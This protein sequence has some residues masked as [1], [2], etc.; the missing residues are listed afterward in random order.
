MKRLLPLAGT[1][2]GALIVIALAFED[3]FWHPNQYF[4]AQG[5]DGFKN[6]FTPAWYLKYDQ[7]WQ[8]SGMNYPYGEHVVFTDNQPLISG[9]LNFIDNNL[10]ELHAYTVG[11]L[12]LLLFLSIALA[13]GCLYLICRHYGIPKW[14]A[15]M[16]AI[17]IVFLSPQLHRFHGHYA[18]GYVVYLPLLWWVQIQ[19]LEHRK[20]PWYLTW[21]A[22]VSLAAWV[23]VYYLLM[24]ILFGLCYFTFDLLFTREKLN[25]KSIA[26]YGALAISPMIIFQIIMTLTDHITDRPSQ[27]YGFFNYRAYLE[28]IFLPNEGP[29]FDFINQLIQVRRVPNEGYAYLGLA[30]S[31]IVVLAIIK[32]AKR[33]PQWRNI[34]ERKHAMAVPLATATTLLLFSM[35]WPFSWGMQGIVEYLGPLQQFRSLGRFA[36][37]PYFIFTVFALRYL[38]QLYRVLSMKQLQGFARGI[39]VIALLFWSWEA[40]TFLKRRALHIR[41]NPATNLLKQP[42]IDYVAWL[43]SLGKSPKDYQAILPIPAYFIG[44]EEFY[45]EF[46]SGL[47]IQESFCA[48]YQTG[49]PLACGMMSRTSFGQTEKLVQ[50]VSHRDLERTLFENYPNRKP[51]L[52]IDFDQV[53]KSYYSQLLIKELN[54]LDKKG[55][56]SLLELP[57]EKLEGSRKRI[58]AQFNNQRD[59]LYQHDSGFLTTIDSCWVYADR[60]D[61][62]QQTAFGQESRQQTSGAIELLGQNISELPAKKWMECSLWLK[63]DH[64]QTAFPIVHIREIDQAGNVIWSKDVNPKFSVDTYKGWA[65]ISHEFQM[66]QQ[67]NILNIYVSGKYMDI[68][69]LLI[70]PVGLDVYQASEELNELMYNNFYYPLYLLSL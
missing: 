26:S 1:I 70:R 44:S 59:S 66:S 13:A 30:G 23:H 38:W 31:I 25:W 6:Y 4:F 8:F 12:N 3:V 41:Q 7:G 45:S 56:I 65:R 39:V 27:P 33:L 50:I 18:L 52:V 63:I 16:G 58:L 47:A 48:A 49:L 35:A 20:W 46:D 42:N 69:S 28:S 53:A 62:A 40:A 22:V 17:L 57:L 54:T 2:L 43:E 11:I 64:Q 24:G 21:V 67:E 37:I 29:I 32:L 14:L 55:Q 51:I 34:L 5:G 61:E 19:L 60:F 36:W 9:F 15:M 10:F 68:E